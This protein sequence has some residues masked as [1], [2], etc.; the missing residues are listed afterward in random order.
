MF[1]F[2]KLVAAFVL[3]PGVFVTLLVLFGLLL[4]RRRPRYPGVVSL[5]LA[6]MVYLLSISPVAQLLMRPLEDD[7]RTLRPP[8]GDVIVVLGGG[9][10][11]RVP[12]VSGI[13]APSFNMLPRIVTAARLQHRMGVPVLVSGGTTRPHGQS[14]AAVARRFL[15]DLGVER[16]MVIIEGHSRDTLENARFTRDLLTAGGYHKPVLVTS[17]YHLQRAVRMFERV[18]LKVTPFP[19]DFFVPAETHFIWRDWLP[20]I[21]GLLVS[22]RALHEYLG[23][24]YYRLVD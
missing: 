13:G 22:R 3:P 21:G 5:L 11:D 4:M 15:E 10:V 19:S 20:S 24:V 23:L 8:K 7:Y 2:E 6:A 12:D 1:A 17:A 18:G 9:I 16:R 14:E